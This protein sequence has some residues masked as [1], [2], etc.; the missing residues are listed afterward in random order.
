[1]NH[2]TP[3]AG[4]CQRC[5]APGNAYTMSIF[6]TRLICLDCKEAERHHPRHAEAA[7]AELASVQ[8]GDMAY[9]GI[10]EIGPCWWRTADGK[11]YCARC[12]PDGLESTPVWPV[13]DVLQGCGS[14]TCHGRTS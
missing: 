10:G 1:M 12:R 3:W 14:K 7:A 9:P 8:A 6:S 2:A 4:R 5:G 11:L 13:A